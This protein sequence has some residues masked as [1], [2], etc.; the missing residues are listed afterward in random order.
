MIREYYDTSAFAKLFI[1]DAGSEEVL[2]RYREATEPTVSRL[3]LVEVRS[4][5]QKAMM[6]G[7]LTFEDAQT[8]HAA[9]D[10][11]IAELS[12]IALSN[13]TFTRAE[14]IV[15]VYS[16]RTLDALQLACAM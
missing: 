4:A 6:I 2:K 14:R 3:A 9:T 11:T 12:I 16:L 1:Q 13:R 15:K 8:V 5:V 7:L 10:A